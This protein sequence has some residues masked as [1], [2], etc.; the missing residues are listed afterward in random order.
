MAGKRTIDNLFISTVGSLLFTIFVSHAV[1]A[2]TSGQG[3][4]LFTLLDPEHTNI[5][6]SNDI[7]ETEHLNIL[8]YEYLHNGGGVATGDLNNNGLPDIFF[9]GNYVANRLYKNN[10]NFQFEE[11]AEEAGLLGTQGWDTGVT[12]VDIN[13]NGYLDIYVCRSGPLPPEHRANQLYINNGDMTFTESAA[14][15]GLDDMGYATQA[16][17]IDYNGNGLLDMFLLNHNIVPMEAFDPAEVTAQ[18]DPYVGDKLFRNNGDGTFT[19]VSE[20][21]GI[22]GNPLGYG[23]GVAVGDLNNN[24][25]TDIYIANDFLERDYIYINNGDGTFTEKL[26]EATKQ[27]VSFS[28]G[29]DIADFN[30]NGWLDILTTDMHAEDHYRQ[31]TNMTGMDNTTFRYMVDDGFHYQYM[32]N[33]LQMN[34][35][36][37]TFSNIGQITGVSYTDWSW[38][39][40]M[41]DFDNDGFKDIFI[42]NGYYKEVA[43]KDYNVYEDEVFDLVRTDPEIE[44]LDKMPELLESIP[45]TPIVNYML[46]N[47]GDLTFTK[48]ME[49]W[50]MNHPG[51][52]AGA[53]Y[54]DL[55]NNGALDLVVANVNDL[56]FIYRN[57]SRDLSGHNFLRFDLQGPANNTS[58]I[59]TRVTIYNGDDLQMIEHYLTR[60]FQSSVEDVLHFGLGDHNEVDRVDVRWPDG[61]VQTLYD[62]PANQIV[63]L[64]YEN[65]YQPEDDSDSSVNEFLFEDITEQ[66]GLSHN[67]DEN[68]YIDFERQPLLPYKMSRLG[69]ALAVGDVNG[70]GLDDFFVGGA[71][72]YSGTLYFQTESGEFESA[73]SQPWENDRISEDVGALFFDSNGNGSLDLYVVSGG[74]E[75][76]TTSSALQDRLYINDGDG[77]FQ[78]AENALPEMRTSG[79]VAVA[80]DFNGNGQLDL[81]IGG[82]VVPGNYPYPPR[83][84]LLENENGMFTDVTST[85]APELY[86][87]GM[88]TDAIW[89][90][91][92][93]NGK[94]DLIVVG[95]WMPIMLMENRGDSFVNI[96]NEENLENSRGWWFSIAEAGLNETGNMDYI[97]GNLGLNHRYKTSPDEPFQVYSKDFN[98]NGRNDIVLAYYN[99]GVLYPRRGRRTMVGQ[100][101]FIENEF[102][103]YHAY[104]S[105]TF[106]EIF[107]DDLLDNALHYK[108][109]TFASSKLQ[110]REQGGFDVVP[111]PNMAQLSSIQGIL[112]EDFDDDGQNDI[113]IA[114]NLYHFESKTPRNDASIGLFLKNDQSGNLGFIPGRKSGLFADGDVRG[115]E[116][117]SLGREGQM[118]ILIPKNDDYL[119]LIK[120]NNITDEITDL[121]E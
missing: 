65:A 94:S 83:S 78:K 120:V 100:F 68:E 58:G 49:E 30:N 6:F 53:A 88:V 13:G 105:A 16:V 55:N 80:G 17:F 115:L 118:G 2:Q 29:N 72:E 52:S 77:N 87:A 121:I 33:A 81:F 114:G 18:R 71:H 39:A 5:L 47:N 50:G 51:F 45:S 84:Y 116:L 95:E 102:P 41:A 48:K 4:T 61:K 62:I 11:I 31:M 27:L 20:E 74:Y 79:S 7:P 60:G 64:S 91:H 42:A 86:E 93:N 23:L 117:I 34:N 97:V 110:S 57:N 21:A 14:E 22:I 26:K 3:E 1:F 75:F 19:E 70:N 85:M 67:H 111:L 8:T 56:P 108:V 104:A 54:A 119:Q 82:R 15:Y 9:T 10:G 38:A 90:D 36:N 103:T 113:V 89:S 12:M 24:G 109:D 44:L 40:L 107:G 99:D 73:S 28:M 96:S 101:P 35:G 32:F 46:R 59:G 63:S 92:N 112:V 25:W 37:E 69:P 43:D 76:S 98:G 66:V 106:T